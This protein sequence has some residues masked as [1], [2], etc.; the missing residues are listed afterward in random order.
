MTGRRLGRRDPGRP[1]APGKAPRTVTPRGKRVL[2]TP[3]SRRDKKLTRV[4][5]LAG[6]GANPVGADIVPPPAPVSRLSPPID[7]LTAEECEAVVAI[8]RAAGGLGAASRELRRRYPDWKEPQRLA[9]LR[10][11]Q[12]AV[13][14][15]WLKNAERK[16][17]ERLAR[18]HAGERLGDEP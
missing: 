5:R 17:R 16:S 11:A 8:L 12:N 4:A 13:F 18:Q 6:F 1:P 14:A 10:Q 3:E 2:L 9:A 7:I 15:D